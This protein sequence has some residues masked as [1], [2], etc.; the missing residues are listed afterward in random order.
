MQ[1]EVAGWTLQRALGSGGHGAV[2]AAR[3]ADGTEAA[4]KLVALRDGDAAQREDFLRRSAL[5][6]GL[7]HPNIVAVLGF[8]VERGLG[9]LAMERVPGR[10][11]AHRTAPA[12]LL[13]LP[14]VLA[15]GEAV[16]RALAH[17]HRHGVVHRDLKPANVLWVEP[18][19]VVKVADL[20]LVHGADMAATETGVV[21]G[22]PAYMA[23]E[24]L[25]GAP[26][27][28]AGD[29]YALGASLFHLLT[30]RLPFDADS[31]G[32]LLRRTWREDAP[33]PRALRPELPA[34]VAAL[35]ARLLARRR[36]QRAADAAAVAQA[37]A[38]LRV[39]G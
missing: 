17:A 37:L 12:R 13:P 23:P 5:A 1:R 10:D 16:A 30:G 26:A 38:A 20:G 25:A 7:V 14:R 18:G 24:V 11:L 8:G 29:L 28:A 35:V 4:L 6:Q 15:V 31:M 21:P 33:D 22:T 19:D 32:V 2:F 9:W 36:E 34:G 3:H 39:A 27:D